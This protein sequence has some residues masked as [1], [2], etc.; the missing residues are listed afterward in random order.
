L[1]FICIL[2]WRPWALASATGVY[3][4]RFILSTVVFA[5]GSSQRQRKMKN[6]IIVGQGI[7]GK[8]IV[9]AYIL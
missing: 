3:V 4:G 7:P 8:N 2:G 9:V 6:G 5:P 1:P